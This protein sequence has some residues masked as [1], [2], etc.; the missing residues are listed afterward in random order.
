MGC[1]TKQL[2]L[3]W[4]YFAR[5]TGELVDH[6]REEKKCGGRGITSTANQCNCPFPL[7]SLSPLF[8]FAS[9]PFFL[10]SH[11]CM[12]CASVSGVTQGGERCQRGKHRAGCLSSD[13]MG[14]TPP[15]HFE[16]KTHTTQPLD[17]IRDGY[18]KSSTFPSS[19]SRSASAKR[20]RTETKEKGNVFH[21]KYF[22][23]LRFLALVLFVLL[24]SLPM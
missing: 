20:S 23:T 1:Q 15:L 21:I 11:S 17:T 4:I 22:L 2:R 19:L 12:W 3:D 10:S 6:H 18:R 24:L 16:S 9:L 8:F 14:N 5:T 13:L 7:S